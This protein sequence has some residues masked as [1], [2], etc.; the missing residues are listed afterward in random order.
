[1][2]LRILGHSMKCL[3]QFQ[4][5]NS[6]IKLNSQIESVL[7][8]SSKPIL[9]PHITTPNN[10]YAELNSRLNLKPIHSPPATSLTASPLDIGYHTPQ[11]LAHQS[12]T[13]DNTNMAGWP[14][15]QTGGKRLIRLNWKLKCKIGYTDDI[16]FDIEWWR[17]WWS[18]SM[19]LFQFIRTSL[20]LTICYSHTL[21]SLDLLHFL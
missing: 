7:S 4:H 10:Q 1:M 3:P 8:T 11:Q 21:V 15:Y 18:N 12:A 13:T 5:Q 9:W 19:A 20:L 16:E 6:S 14:V 17:W 2:V